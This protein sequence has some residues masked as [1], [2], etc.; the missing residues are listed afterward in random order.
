MKRVFVFILGIV[1]MGFIACQNRPDANAE[2]NI[3]KVIAED[4]VWFNSNTQVDST[5]DSSMH[6]MAEDSFTVIWWRGPETHPDTNIDI[7]VVGDSA[8]VKW[9]RKNVG[10]LHIRAYNKNTQQW[11]S[12]DKDLSETVYMNAIFKRDGDLSKHD[13]WVLKKIS[14]AVAT[15]D[16]INTVKIDSLKIVSKNGGESKV[17]I[18]PLNTFYDVD[19]LPAF[20]PSEHVDVEVYTNGVNGNVFLHTFIL[21]WPFYLRFEIEQQREGFYSKE[22]VMQAIP[23]PRFAIFDLLHHNTL[24]TA[25]YGYDFHGI[26]FPYSIK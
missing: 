26:F 19:D 11:S 3:R 8:F 2:D 16:I 6:I 25:E 7:S 5:S 10:V 4:T 22:C 20:S 24:Y 18:E 17:V 13:G 1:L 21:L 12:W 15:S 23:F 14:C 9:S